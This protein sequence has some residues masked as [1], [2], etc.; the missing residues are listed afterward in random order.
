LRALSVCAARNAL[1]CCRAA[2]KVPGL[3]NLLLQEALPMLLVGVLAATLA[4]LPAS[5]P[6]A[7]DT[8]VSV[9]RAYAQRSTAASTPRL[10]PEVGMKAL[11][12]G[13]AALALTG[14]QGLLATEGLPLDD[15]G[16]VSSDTRQVLALLLGLLVGFGIGHLVA[17]DRDGFILFLIVDLAIITISSVLFFATPFRLGYLALFIS[18]VI[19]GL[20]A[21][22]KAGGGSLVEH[23]RTRAVEIAGLPGREAP[24]ITTR[25]FA[26]SF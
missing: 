14:P 2:S 11:N 15:G 26:Y 22:A 8:S 25:A 9:T 3:R 19:Q 17:R 6:A 4:S 7:A 5:I 16:G 13:T 12:V 1:A 18:H 23:T 21:Y 20:D 10:L 24:H